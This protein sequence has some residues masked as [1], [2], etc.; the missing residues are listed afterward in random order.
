[1]GHY[2]VFNGYDDA[3]K[4]LVA[5]DSLA[6]P[7][8]EYPY[9]TLETDWRAFNYVYMVIYPPE[10]EADVMRILGPQADEK[11]NYEYAA[12]KASNEVMGL[13]G[14]EKFFALYNR[15]T[16][17]VELQDYGG[18]SQIYDEAFLSDWALQ[19]VL[20]HRSLLERDQ[21]CHSNPG[22]NDQSYC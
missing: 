8:Q 11:S 6:G 3:G 19:G 2:M 20:L 21:P 10:K 15:G 12:L 14:R 16:N 17:L 5:Q 22:H 13:S 7:D 4:F 9:E 1:M 18:A